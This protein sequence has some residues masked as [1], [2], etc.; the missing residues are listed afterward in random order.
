MTERFGTE[1]C[2]AEAWRGK[3]MRAG[4]RKNLTTE[5][6]RH[7]AAKPQPKGGNAIGGC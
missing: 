7:S 6:R 3:Q 2:E 5:T 4:M 1:K